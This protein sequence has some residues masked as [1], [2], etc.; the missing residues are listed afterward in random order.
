MSTGNALFFQV[1]RPL[2]LFGI[3]I[4]P[5]LRQLDA[6]PHERI[7]DAG[8]GYGYLVKRLNH[9]DYTGVDLDHE[10]I[11]WANKVVEFA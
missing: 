10:R 6:Q 1:L 7:L 4:N 5:V 3:R 9:C 11:E 2:V 8:C